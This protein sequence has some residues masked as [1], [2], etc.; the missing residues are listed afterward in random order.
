MSNA[1]FP[2]PPQV[3]VRF[4]RRSRVPRWLAIFGVILAAGTLMCCIGFV[5]LGL[6]FGP[7]MTETPAEVQ[8]IANRIA[9]LR[10]PPQFEPV[11]GW[12]AD[13]SLAWVQI[14]R[15]QQKDHRGLLMIGELHLRPFTVKY[16]PA[17]FREFLESATPGL[18][19]I[20]AAET[21]KRT[22]TIHGQPAKFDVVSGED[23]AS[24]TK[25]RQVTGTFMGRVGTVV[26]ILQAE[27]ESLS[28]QAIN[29]FLTSLSE[30]ANSEK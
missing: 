27:P 15:F 10:V 29:D 22:L 19:L 8:A 14:A 1:A 23:R 9:P 3:V 20:D 13:N 28:D 17:Q 26:V 25:L 18:R 2:T 7:S 16:D 4:R 6:I 12:A 30:S 11:E 5:S 21:S 24:T